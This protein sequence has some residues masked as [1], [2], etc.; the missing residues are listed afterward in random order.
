MF[1]SD[2]DLS[3]F[4]EDW[5]RYGFKSFLPD[6]QTLVERDKASLTTIIIKNYERERECVRERER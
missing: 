3:S 4:F 2:P 1:R 5:I 6:P